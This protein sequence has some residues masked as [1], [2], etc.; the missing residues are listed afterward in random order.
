MKIELRSV[1]HYPS[2]SEETE[3]FE[4]RLIVDGV[5]IGRISNRGTGGCDEFFGDHAVYKKADE[6]CRANLPKWGSEF[7]G[8]D[9]HDS[10]LEIHVAELLNEWIA[11]KD[12]RAALAKKALFVRAG[13]KGIF[14][15][16]YKNR[17]Q[18]PDGRLFESVRR[19]NPGARILNELPFD[20]ALKLYR[21][22]A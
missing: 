22:A 8:A 14:E 3:C 5:D 6:W 13:V 9:T 20:E 2:M 12:L 4:A 19:A 21:S 1:K 16:R 18:K 11:A 15:T 7:G 17:T 10:D